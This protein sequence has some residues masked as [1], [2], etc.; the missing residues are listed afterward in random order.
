[1]LIAKPHCLCLPPFTSHKAILHVQ[2]NCTTRWIYCKNGYVAKAKK[3]LDSVVE[4]N[5]GL[6]YSEGRTDIIHNIHHAVISCHVT[7]M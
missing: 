6:G 2:L 5:N 7:L 3:Y 1:M 4:F